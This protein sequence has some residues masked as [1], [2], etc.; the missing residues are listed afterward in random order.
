ME[1][2]LFSRDV[3][4]LATAVSLSHNVFDAALMLGVCDKIVPGLVMG[5][6]AFGHLPVLFVP[7]GPMATG[8][9]NDEKTR[10][11]KAYEAGELNRAALLAAEMKSYHGPGTCTFY[12]TANSNQMLMEFMG[13]HVPGSAFVHPD[14]PLRATM[15]REAVRIAILSSEGPGIGEILDERAFVNGIVG[16]HATGGSTNHLIHLVAMAAAS[17]IQLRWD[18]FADLA[19]IVPLLARVY[20]NGPADVNQFHA[21]G[22]LAFVMR[23]L[24]AA[25]RKSVV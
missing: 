11:R 7:A 2:S 23:E 9:A 16:L 5:A 6:L 10:V 21:A 12:G 24:L 1:L 3:I 17:G 18:D 14:S 20:P 25:D 15:T 19:R 22:G 8:L 4:A 13:L